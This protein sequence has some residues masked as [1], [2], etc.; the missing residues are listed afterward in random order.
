MNK[1]R[2]NRWL[3][4]G[5]NLGVLV[6]I[7][8]LVVELSQNRATVRAQTRHAISVE[9]TNFL[10]D[11]AYSPDMMD[12]IGRAVRGEELTPDENLR[13]TFRINAWFQIAANV[14]YQYRQGLF[15]DS[16]FDSIKNLWRGIGN[17]NP[18]IAEIWCQFRPQYAPEFQAEMN[19]QFENLSC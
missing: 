16:E 11:T 15:D 9:Y 1:I 12:I 7:L 5:A 17:A 14:H 2:V 19:A 4:L 3:T 18:R 13:Y 8:L 10:T 6:G